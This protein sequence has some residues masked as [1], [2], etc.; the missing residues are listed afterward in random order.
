[1]CMSYVHYNCKYSWKHQLNLQ[2]VD[3]LQLREKFDVVLFLTCRENIK[4][5][6]NFLLQHLLFAEIRFIY[7]L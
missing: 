6:L 4:D 5:I 2:P 3:A 7:A 1:M